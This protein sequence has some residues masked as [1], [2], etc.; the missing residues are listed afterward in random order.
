MTIMQVILRKKKEPGDAAHHVCEELVWIEK[1][2]VRP[3]H[4]EVRCA[5]E[6]KANPVTQPGTHGR[7][8][9]G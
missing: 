2:C 8:E 9:R 7:G 5:R 6:Q 1:Q 3:R 4:V